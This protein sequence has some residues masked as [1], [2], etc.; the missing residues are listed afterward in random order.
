MNRRIFLVHGHDEEMK[1][2]VARFLERL[3]FEAIILHE[4]PNIGKTIIEKFEANS[5]VGYAVILLAP[6]DI[7]YSRLQPDSVASR[8][9]QNVIMELGFFLGKL[10]RNK[11]SILVRI[12]K[13][14]EFPT[15]IGGMI[16]TRY[17]ENGGWRLKLAQELHSV[18]YEIDFTRIPM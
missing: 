15:D 1:Q 14:F 18:G 3:E 13:D 6:D 10:G 12:T 2:S 17:D 11:V 5:D 7:G 8:A 4:R 16:Y 9:R